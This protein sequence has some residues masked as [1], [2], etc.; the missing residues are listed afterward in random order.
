MTWRH[1][2]PGHFILLVVGLV[3][4]L[5]AVAVAVFGWIDIFRRI[6]FLIFLKRNLNFPHVLFR[7]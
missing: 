2:I 3:F 6:Y 4:N 7:V 1:N 5:A